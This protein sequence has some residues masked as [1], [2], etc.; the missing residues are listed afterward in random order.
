M[1]GKVRAERVCFGEHWEI[2]SDS[3]GLHWNA[4]LPAC[5]ST[6]WAMR[7]VCVG[8]GLIWQRAA[9]GKKFTWHVYADASR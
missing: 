2:Y 5:G 9:L 3:R 1:S 8:W 6:L 4:H 7:A